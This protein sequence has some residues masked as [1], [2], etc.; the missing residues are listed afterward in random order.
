MKRMP[1]LDPTRRCLAVTVRCSCKTQTHANALQ[2][3]KLA[4]WRHPS[5]LP[6][7]SLILY[8]TDRTE[9]SPVLGQ[10]LGLGRLGGCRRGRGSSRLMDV[11]VDV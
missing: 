10:G 5:S 2:T 9:S 7:Q 8:K 3:A 11:D 1:R 4:G 6:S